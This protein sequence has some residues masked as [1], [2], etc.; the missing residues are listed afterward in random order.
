DRTGAVT[1]VSAGMPIAIPLAGTAPIQAN[2]SSSTATATSG[3]P[4]KLTW[5]ASPGASCMATGGSTT[6]GWTG[7]VKASGTQSVT[8]TTAGTYSYGLSCTAGSQS[9]S[10][11]T[12]VVVSW[13]ALTVSLM[14]S[15]T[16]ITSGN[17]TTLT[18][19]SANAKTCA[20]S[21]GGTDDGWAGSIQATSG[22]AAITEPVAV[23]SPLTLTYTLTCS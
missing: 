21:G 6:D 5:T 1:V 23:A 14:A 16:T 3:V 15:P 8:E 4:V 18:W 20:A 17:S 13:P 12:T 19:T 10:T 9:K 7:A 2:I 22:S 11:Q